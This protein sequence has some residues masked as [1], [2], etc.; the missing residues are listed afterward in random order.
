MRKQL[1]NDDFFMVISG[2]FRYLIK[3]H[4]YSRPGEENL[5]FPGIPGAVITLSI[6][7]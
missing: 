7:H 6:R 4:T 5:V 2:I 1:T 3:F